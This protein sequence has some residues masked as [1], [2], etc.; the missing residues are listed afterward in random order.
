MHLCSLDKLFCFVNVGYYRWTVLSRPRSGLVKVDGI[1]LSCLASGIHVVF[2][3]HGNAFKNVHGFP[4]AQASMGT[5]FVVKPK[6]IVQCL[7]EVMPC[8]QFCQIETFMF[9]WPPQAFFCTFHSNKHHPN[10][11][12]CSTGFSI[13][14]WVLSVFTISRALS[15]SNSHS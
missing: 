11:D 4:I 9:H 14:N 5:L 13:L 6:P 3:L 10:N 1:S 15:A 8:C 12:N 7:S 2:S